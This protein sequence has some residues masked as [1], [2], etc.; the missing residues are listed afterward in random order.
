MN[1]YSDF[2]ASAETEYPVKGESMAVPGKIRVRNRDLK[3]AIDA[4]LAADVTTSSGEV[5]TG[6]E[7][8]ACAL[9]SKAV[10]GD[11]KSIQI[12]LDLIYGRKQEVEMKGAANLPDLHVQILPDMD[13]S[14]FTPEQL[15]EMG[16]A[17]F[18]GEYDE[19][20]AGEKKELE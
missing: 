5:M 1:D 3:A 19:S 12:I 16:R 18:R 9:V 10:N 7:V 2:D 14:K 4:V 11:L 15:I 6:A 17:A 20:L 13:F 8:I